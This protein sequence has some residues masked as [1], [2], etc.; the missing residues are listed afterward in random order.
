RIF[1]AL[2]LSAAEAA[3]LLDGGQNAIT[4]MTDWWRAGVPFD[5]VA[6]WSAAGFSATEAAA[7]CAAGTDLEQAK[8]L[9]ALTA[10]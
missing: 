2:S 4:V 8:I 10:D 7:Q 5:D 6:A 9:R 3:R 1:R